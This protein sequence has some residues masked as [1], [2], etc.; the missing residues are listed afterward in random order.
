MKRKL[1]AIAVLLLFGLIKLPVEEAA[2][3]QLRAARLLS[4]P[5]DLS[6][7]ENIG[8]M[9]FAAALGGLRSLIASITYLQAYQAWENIDWAKVD[10][11]FQ[12]TTTL[13]P[14]YANYWDEAAW[15][16][17][18]NAASSYLNNQELNS[19]VRGKL[20]HDHI[21]RGIAIL[22]DGLR[23]LPD[24]PRLWNGLAE[25]YERRQIDPRKSAECY[26]QL[27]R[28]TKNPRYGRFAAYQLALTSDPSQW[29]RAYDLLK[30]AYDQKQR[31]PTLI[32]TLKSLEERLEIPANQ[33]IPDA[34]VPIGQN[35]NQ[36]GPLR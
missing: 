32:N 12:L 5:L 9:S 24:E 34:L 18:Y 14:R 13:Q 29:Q 11:L 16:M 6:V 19:A 23:V 20:Y 35:Q 26:L 28:V 7:R 36:A 8:Q 17:A 15:Q 30:S 4:P 22:R 31:L 25:I 27:L 3:R 2:T 10:S 33:R 21:D 1:Q